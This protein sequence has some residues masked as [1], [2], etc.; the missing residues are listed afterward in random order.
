M[1]KP[2]K[3]VVE[4]L[5]SSEIKKYLT[6]RVEEAKNIIKSKDETEEDKQRACYEKEVLL[7][8]LCE[9]FEFGG[10]YAQKRLEKEM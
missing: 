1:Q 5:T 6:L 2:L 9:L 3:V 7:D 8:C 4:E 10:K